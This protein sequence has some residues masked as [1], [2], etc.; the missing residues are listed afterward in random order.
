MLDRIDWPQDGYRL[1]DIASWPRQGSDIT[2]WL[3]PAYESNALFMSRDLWSETG[4]YDLGFQTPG[5][6]FSSHDLFSRA[7][8][9]PDTQLIHV[10][11]EAT[12]HQF[13]SD[14]SSSAHADAPNQ[15]MRFARE[16]ARLRQTKV[17]PI[18][19]PFWM[20][21]LAPLS[22]SPPPPH[23]PAPDDRY[24]ALLKQ[25]ILNEPNLELEA[26]LNLVL[27]AGA[28]EPKDAALSDAVT[29][30]RKDRRDGRWRTRLPETLS[31][32]GRKR[33]DQLGDSVQTILSDNIPGDL[34]ECG[35]WRG[36][37][38]ILMAA[39]LAAH[40]STDRTI[41][42]ADSFAGFP[43]TNSLATKDE[44]S[45]YLDDL[46]RAH[47]DL[48]VSQDA[49][50]ANLARFGLLGPHIRFLRGWFSDTLPVAPVEK[51]A[52]LRLDGDSFG[53]TTLALDHLYHKLSV[54]GFLIVD[55]YTIPDCRAAVTAFRDRCGVTERIQRIDWM[56][57]YWRK[58]A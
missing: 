25:V 34:M 44:S 14:S 27:A 43:L 3:T 38:G 24:I 30:L 2:R 54:G 33:L 50:Q 23:D 31:M 55:D 13:H 56:G 51:L 11:G 57:V 58:G 20:V 35:V 17:R 21:Q 10:L 40:K 4:G 1:F 37:A 28:V 12:F 15:M 9:L 52:L 26:K 5:G 29:Q 45:A 46:L 49:V 48:A 19:K 47:P 8:A 6:G 22:D 36:G 7:C 32:I 53:A 18:T 41:W 39:L 42:L 16:Y